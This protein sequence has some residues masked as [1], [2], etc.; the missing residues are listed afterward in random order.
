MAT[1][2]LKNELVVGNRS[3]GEAIVCDL[4]RF[5]F[6]KLVILPNDKTAIGKELDIYLPQYRIACEINGPTHQRVVFSEKT[7]IKTIENDKKKAVLCDEAGIK[8]I[9]INLPEDS[10]LYYSF[11]KEEIKNRVVP[12]IQAW[13]S[14]TSSS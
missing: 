2:K 9:P 7:F 3:Q 6:K 10:R 13:L 4:L 1:K 14:L 5:Y 12:E 11:L 8:L